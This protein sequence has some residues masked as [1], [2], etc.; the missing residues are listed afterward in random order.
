MAVKVYRSTDT[1]APA[2]SGQAGKLI[3]VLDACLVNGY[4]SKSS[5]GW[6]KEYSGTNNASYQMPSGT[7]QCSLNV[8]DT[9]TQTARLRGFHDATTYG[10]GATCG[11]NPFPN[12]S[13]VSG[14]LYIIKSGTAD[15]VARP[16]VLVGDDT[17]FQ[18]YAD[19][20]SNQ[21]DAKTMFFGD[22]H[23][24]IVSDTNSCAIIG[25]CTSSGY[26]TIPEVAAL[27]L[28]NSQH[29]LALRYDGI[30]VSY[31]FGKIPMRGICTYNHMSTNT[32]TGNFLPYPCPITGRLILS[33]MYVHEIGSGSIGAVLRGF[34]PGL[35]FIGHPTY[36]FNAGDI[37]TGN[38]G[39]DLEGKEFQV[40]QS[41]HDTDGRI[42]QFALEISDTQ[43]DTIWK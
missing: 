15:A 9:G 38:A 5:M 6:T 14:G 13:Q 12:D 1:S 24:Y 37:I 22:I 17:R 11:T 18:L 19:K 34:L 7:S 23:S 3:D 27:Q 20:Q 43:L 33:P 2:L 31:A 39:T 42:G 26:A 41:R 30:S 10:V 25:G 29:Y 4:G 16:Q 40:F 8:D 36:T 21:T 28:T 35:W 32:V